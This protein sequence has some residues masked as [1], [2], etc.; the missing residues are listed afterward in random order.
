MAF[1]YTILTTDTFDVWRSETNNITNH[2]SANV[3]LNNFD[4]NV[5]PTSTDDQNSGYA[6]GSKWVNLTTNIAYE[7]V[8]SSVSAAVW[9]Q[10]LN[11]NGGSVGDLIVTGA[12]TS[13]GIDDNA[14]GERLNLA[15]SIANFG[16]NAAEGNYI[17]GTQI[18][19]GTL[20]VSAGT[21][22]T[23]G[24]NLEL[25]GINHPTL[26]YD[27]A[28]RAGL[29]DTLYWD[30]S[31]N[32][33]TVV[34]NLLAPIVNVTD[35][36][37][38]IE[39]AAA[40]A[41]T[42][43]TG[44]LWIRDDAP[45][46]LIFTSDTGVDHVISGAGTGGPLSDPG[47][48]GTPYGRKDNL[49]VEVIDTLGDQSIA[50]TTTLENLSLTGAL[51]GNTISGTTNIGTLATGDGISDGIY[52]WA[53]Q[54]G[55][56]G[57]LPDDG[58]L[59]SDY[60]QMLQTSDTGQPVQLW[61]GGSGTNNMG[62]AI[63]RNSSG[64][65]DAWTHFIH[66]GGGQTINGNLDINADFAVKSGATDVMLFSN[67]NSVG[68][69]PDIQFNLA[70]LIAAQ[71]DFHINLDSTNSSSSTFYLRSGGNTDAATQIMSIDETATLILSKNNTST[72]VASVTLDQAGTGDSFQTFGVAA[73]KW[74]MGIDNSDADTF[75]ISEGTTLGSAA[76][77]I[78][79]GGLVA[80][81]G[82]VAANVFSGAGT[83][84]SGTAASLTAG[85]VT[86]NANL[87]GHITSTGNSSSLGSFTS[88]DL[89]TALTNGTGTGAAVFAGSPSFT[90][91]MITTGITLNGNMAISDGDGIDFSATSDG[92]GT[93]TSSILID[94]EEGTWTPQ[95]TDQSF[96]IDES[97]AFTSGGLYTKIGRKVY[98]EG[99]ISMTSLGS[100]NTSD[101]AC[102]IN[103]PYAV[104]SSL[105][106]L[107]GGG[108]I[109]YAFNLN[110]TTASSLTT[111]VV[112][113]SYQMVIYKWSATATGGT[114][115]FTVGELSSFGSIH[116]VFNYNTV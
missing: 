12:F 97:Q 7:L 34:G 70:G 49:W 111:K 19:D 104:A 115:N 62:L 13:I 38:I 30:N 37:A 54:S 29:T 113:N 58:R 92:T 108:I 61:W 107:S 90:G 85:N 66:D 72:T 65:W 82:T 64:T 81:N 105:N 100:L 102:I 110:L 31:N 36:I 35:D 80:V 53:N 2:I 9:N 28:L 57:T 73:K 48:D 114:S 18:N 33:L 109:N 56:T 99:W 116:F 75:K 23:N 45:N 96:S 4:A 17:L 44:R 24:A 5:A 69:A 93:A 14:T 52:R 16:D 95:L 68:T 11:I 25:Q 1:P 10:Y 60:G 71:T 94:Y 74:S 84:L 43:G 55:L 27:W 98:C 6:V 21:N 78:S 91:T 106:Y 32:L 42:A 50:G 15:D 77:E 46:N 3:K 63:R 83:N 26:A 101:V 22:L 112:P 67:T 76:L 40:T 88:G 103:L 47:S 79:T 87:T 86:T 8:D 89:R 59:N 20:Y 51:V 41:A 39:K